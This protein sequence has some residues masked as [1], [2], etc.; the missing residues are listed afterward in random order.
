MDYVSCPP[1]YTLIFGSDTEG[2]IIFY[3]KKAGQT[4]PKSNLRQN[5]T[6][7]SPDV[8]TFV[9]SVCPRLAACLQEAYTNYLSY[10]HRL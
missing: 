1:Q 4:L 2:V 8:R 9:P 7:V 5:H 10:K 3:Q 6:E